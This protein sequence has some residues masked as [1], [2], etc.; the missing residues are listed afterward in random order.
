MQIQ[1]K[2]LVPQA[3]IPTYA[4]LGSAAF[5]FYSIQEAQICYGSPV[6]FDTGL[7]LKIPENHALLI[8]SRSG[9]GFKE[10]IRL[11]NAVGVIDSDYTGEIKIKLSMDFPSWQTSFDVKPGDRI[12]QGLIINTEKISFDI[13]EEL[14]K[15]ERG[16]GGLG[17]TGF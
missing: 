10:N 12:A 4:T 11:S 13:V 14:P 3:R 5:D 9:H 2:K 1:V 17:S 15:T 8:F 7:A 6:I 16:S